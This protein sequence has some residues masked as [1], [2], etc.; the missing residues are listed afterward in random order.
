MAIHL[1]LP[2][3]R[4][5]LRVSIACCCRVQSYRS[6]PPPAGEDANTIL[7]QENGSAQLLKLIEQATLAELSLRGEIVR[8]SRLDVVEYDQ[9]RLPVAKNLRIRV[10]TLDDLVATA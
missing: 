1:S 5:W 7:Q 9:E 10:A 2:P 3:S 4:L 6:R 8:L